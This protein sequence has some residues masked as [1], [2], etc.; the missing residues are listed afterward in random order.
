MGNRTMNYNLIISVN[1]LIILIFLFRKLDIFYI[2]TLLTGYL[3]SYIFLSKLETFY[4]VQTNPKAVCKSKAK[5][6][7]LR[8]RKKKKFLAK[9]IKKKTEKKI[10]AK[11]AGKANKLACAAEA[12]EQNLKGSEKKKFMKKCKKKMKKMDKFPSKR[13]KKK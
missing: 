1:I 12:K 10:A 9:C 6:K 13:C 4:F 8:G 2:I 5:K 7:K 3:I 11:E